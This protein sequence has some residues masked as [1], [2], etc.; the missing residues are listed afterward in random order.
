MSL[1]EF[2]LVR[3][4]NTAEAVSF[5]AQHGP[6]AQVIAGGTDLIPSMR[7]RLFE[8]KYLV[9]LRSI[10]EI[11]GIRELP[12]GSVE[13]GALTTIRQIEH[14]EII[15]SRYPVVAEAARTIASPVIRN[16]GTI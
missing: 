16:M 1:P 9:D 14:S 2:K 11:R 6:E 7:Q 12:D 10:G 8:P 5:L 13:I 4:R 3:P 15:R